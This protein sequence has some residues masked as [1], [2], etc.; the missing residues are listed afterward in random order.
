MVSGQD[1]RIA[2][3]IPDADGEDTVEE[4]KTARSPLLVAVDDDLGVGV[5][6]E[7]VAAIG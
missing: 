7:Q 4:A 2:G 1:Q 6:P 5:G 3:F